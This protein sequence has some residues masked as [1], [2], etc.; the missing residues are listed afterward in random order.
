[1]LVATEAGVPFNQRHPDR[2]SKHLDPNSVYALRYLKPSVAGAYGDVLTQFQAE[3]E[4]SRISMSP[5]KQ[6][7]LARLGRKPGSWR[8]ASWPEALAQ[9]MAETKDYWA[10]ETEWAICGASNIQATKVPS[11][12][13]GHPSEKSNISPVV[14]QPQRQSAWRRCNVPQDEPREAESIKL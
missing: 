10:K 13:V 1:M 11:G 5:A 3:K 8:R 14:S 2:S 7:K 4:K 12:L 9:T 6:K